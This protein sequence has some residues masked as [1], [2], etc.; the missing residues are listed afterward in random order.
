MANT[1]P[2]QAIEAVRGRAAHSKLM[3]Q[4][5]YCG[6]IELLPQSIITRRGGK[7]YCSWKCRQEAMR[8]ENAP[9]YGGGSKMTKEQNP[10]WRG[11]TSFMRQGREMMAEQAKWRRLVFC[12]D[13][14]ICQR[15]GYNKGKKLNA[16][17]KASWSE[18]P[19]KR[20]E[21]SNGVTLC[22]E[23][24]DWVH[25]EENINNELLCKS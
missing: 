19:D 12:R 21:L 1:N 3:F 4:C 8:G 24:H 23:C 7:K 6:H 11:G 13:K 22:K 5:L 25:S 16:H 15:C 18:Y 17:H 9:N 14:Y 20:F 10:M 2:Y